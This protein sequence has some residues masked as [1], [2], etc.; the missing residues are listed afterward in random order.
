MKKKIII[1]I[2]IA[3]LLSTGWILFSFLNRIRA[4]YIY[5]GNGSAVQ[6][7]LY[8]GKAQ[9]IPIDQYCKVNLEKIVWI[10]QEEPWTAKMQEKKVFLTDEHGQTTFLF[11]TNTLKAQLGYDSILDICIT[12]N[13]KIV[14]VAGSEGKRRLVEYKSGEFVHLSQQPVAWSL[15]LNQNEVLATILSD[16]VVHGSNKSVVAIDM[17]TNEMQVIAQ[18]SFAAR[19]DQSRLL[20]EKQGQ[21]ND[22]IVIESLQNARVDQV[23]QPKDTGYYLLIANDSPIISDNQ[24]NAM[25]FYMDASGAAGFENPGV[26]FYDAGE[27]KSIDLQQYFNFMLLKKMP[28]LTGGVPSHAMNKL[29]H[30][31]KEND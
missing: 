5:F 1:C 3:F 24:K 2:I 7:N 12:K 18:G 21:N 16:E 9:Y 4:T 20:Y 31:G 10:E 28:L 14:F 30:H 25:I 8:N 11:D 15:S 6:I 23:A 26:C 13:N 17:Q 19:I 29:V 27:N 22:G